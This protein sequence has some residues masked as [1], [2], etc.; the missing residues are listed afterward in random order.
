MAIARAK[1]FNPYVARKGKPLGL[2]LIGLA[3]VSLLWAVSLM[4]SKSA[5]AGAAAFV[6]LAATPNTVLAPLAS[7][8]LVA[9]GVG[10]D[11]NPGNVAKKQDFR[12]AAKTFGGGKKKKGK[13][14]EVVKEQPKIFRDSPIMYNGK[15][16]GTLNGTIAE[17]KVDIWSGAHPIWQGKKGKVLLDASSVTKFQERFGFASDIFGT[18]GLE[19]LERN[20]KIKAEQEERERLGLKAY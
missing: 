8:G 7:R 9:R 12:A 19:Q 17:Y 13:K 14:E 15:K 3:V 6:G 16:V 10:R 11:W 5:T 18:A 1:E 2:L 20:K 4:S